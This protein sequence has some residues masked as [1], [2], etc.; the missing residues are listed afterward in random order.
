MC[1][2][3]TTFQS[4]DSES[5]N[6]NNQKTEG[7]L[8]Y[9]VI[10][11][12]YIL[13]M[14]MSNFHQLPSRN[15]LFQPPCLSRKSKDQRYRD[16]E[17]MVVLWRLHCCHGRNVHLEESFTRDLQDFT[18]G[19]FPKKNRA[20]FKQIHCLGGFGESPKRHQMAIVFHGDSQVQNIPSQEFHWKNIWEFIT[21][22]AELRLEEKLTSS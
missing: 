6:W 7:C 15:S 13:Y 21:F 12:V 16:L 5:S 2:E 18:V 14:E 3:T 4:K 9:Q 22:P 19:D 10:P 17:S 20:I 8:E 1:C 11:G